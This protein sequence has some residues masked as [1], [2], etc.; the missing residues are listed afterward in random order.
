[1][2]LLGLGTWL[3]TGSQCEKA[4]QMALDMGY[5]HIDTSDDYNNEEQIGK[6]IRGYD[7]SKMFITSKVDDAKLKKDD[8]IKACQESLDRLGIDYLDLY[9]IHRPN[10]LIPITETMEGM[11][12]LIDQGLI[13]GMG[14]SNFSIK[15]TEEAMNSTDIP[16]C[17]NQIKINPYH[18][19]REDIEYLK[20]QDIV[21]TAYSPLGH[22]RLVDDAFLSDIG[23]KYGKTASQVSLRWLLDQKLIVIPKARTKDHL[24]ED[25][26]VFDWDLSDEDFDR[27]AEKSGSNIERIKYKLKTIKQ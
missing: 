7:R 1:M 14:I 4:V 19:P 26:D 9:L 24:R 10:P 20:N 15:Q 11:K 27:I 6:A 23:K 25:I 12:E 3:L 16:V 13:R 18:Y 5:P 2:P 22:G 21:V 8:V 17:V